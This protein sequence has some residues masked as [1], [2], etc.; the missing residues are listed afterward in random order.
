MK[1]ADLCRC[2]GIDNIVPSGD[3]KL[4]DV[5]LL[6]VEKTMMD[7]LCHGDE[8]YIKVMKGKYDSVSLEMVAEVIGHQWRIIDGLAE[9]VRQF[10]EEIL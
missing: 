9:K 6:E 7:Q 10:D 4:V 2:A 5:Q 8:D 3:D 1:I